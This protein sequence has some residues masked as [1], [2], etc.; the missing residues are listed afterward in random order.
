MINPREIV[1]P[2]GRKRKRYDRIVELLDLKPNETILNIGCGQGFT[3]ENFN[4]ENPITGIDLFPK[5]KIHQKNFKYIQRK[6]DKLPFKDNQFD[7]VV[8]IGVLEHIH[9]YET[10]KTTCDEIQ[11]VGKKFLML[12]PNY[13]TLVE[14]HYSFPLFQLLPVNT[15]RKLTETFGLKMPNDEIGKRDRYIYE[16]LNYYKRKD[17]LKF[18]PGAESEIYFH[19]GLLITNL[20]VYRS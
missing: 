3:F 19:I 1:N 17:W 4:K 11:R 10:L 12:V 18:F 13:W 14:P 6:A 2:V 7:A 5:S 9:P 15:Q 16:E 20:I 8:C